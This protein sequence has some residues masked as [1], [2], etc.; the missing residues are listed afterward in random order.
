MKARKPSFISFINRYEHQLGAALNS[1]I[2]LAFIY[3]MWGQQHEKFE[4]KRELLS[5]LT[6]AQRLIV[7]RIDKLEL[8]T[9]LICAAII[10]V[11]W[12]PSF[13]L[14]LRIHQ[15]ENFFASWKAYKSEQSKENDI[16]A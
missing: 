7:Q 10:F 14:R 12:I 9:I 6:E 2:S 1:S 5:G 3:W 4:L 8:H 16:Q 15:K 13:L 11:M